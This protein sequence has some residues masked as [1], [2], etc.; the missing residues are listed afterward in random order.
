M[1][2]LALREVGAGASY[3]LHQGV[4]RVGTARSNTVVLVG[5]SVSR[6]HA[7]LVVEPE[8]VT[9]EDLASKNGTYL[10]DQS[11]RSASV[12]VGDELRFGSVALRVEAIAPDDGELAIR[13]STPGSSAGASAAQVGDTAARRPPQGQSQGRSLGQSLGSVELDGL[14]ALDRAA[15]RLHTGRGCPLMPIVEVIAAKAAAVLE[16]DPEGNGVPAVRA[17]AGEIDRLWRDPAWRDVLTA[18]EP[19]GT[20]LWVGSSEADAGV[21]IVMDRGVPS[22]AVVLWGGRGAG[23]LRQALVRMLVR[24]HGLRGP[25]PVSSPAE[26]AEP[27]FP[28]GYVPGRS[29]VMTALYDRVRR[30]APSELPV[31]VLGETGT[32]KD[33]V[34]RLLHHA[35]P[36][37]GA[38]LVAVNCA[39]IPTEMLEA[40][41]FGVAAGAATGVKPRR[42][43]FQ[44][45]SGGTLFLDEIGDMPLGL[46]AKLLRALEGG[47]VRPVGGEE[48]PVDVWLVSATN[49]AL[50][51]RIRDGGF[52][53]D[54]YYRLAGAV[55]TLPPL[56]ERREDIPALVEH[57]VRRAC[58]DS[59]AFVRGITV[60][61]LRLLCERSWPGNV[62]ELEHLVRQLVFLCPRG[63]PIDRTL[64]QSVRTAD[65]EADE[66][67]DGL[68]PGGSERWASGPGVPGAGVPGAN[69]PEPE[70]EDTLELAVLERRAIQEALV[71]AAGKQVRAAALLG[72]SRYALHRRMRHLGLSASGES[73]AIGA[74]DAED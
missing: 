19:D 23:P 12:T 26:P 21:T 66:R 8:R 54:L 20:G 64:V 73:D 18:V 72:I 56:R 31:L 37:R 46:Q 51:R 35:S 39:A 6:H 40:E 22:R 14:A 9:V 50:G 49:R 17:A 69:A 30:L 33:T 53:R 60:P 3:R 71:R 45:A 25:G 34:A 43:Q 4:N 16:L 67:D 62:R 28:A 32:G 57:F 1:N 15:E 10:N 41:L 68:D 24:L 52:R 5:S 44:R 55:L 38:P 59:G 13:L 11:V 7:L 65:V 42:G 47:T 36:R 70:P 27:G 61:A 58:R 74:A 2:G 48:Q 63:Q 29:T